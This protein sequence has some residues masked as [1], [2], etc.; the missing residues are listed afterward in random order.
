MRHSSGFRFAI[1]AAAG[2]AACAQAGC[3]LDVTF[4]DTDRNRDLIARFD[5]DEAAQ[6]AQD[7]GDAQD[8]PDAA[9]APPDAEPEV[10]PPIDGPS[11]ADALAWGGLL[12]RHVQG[13]CFDYGA[14]ARSP[15]ALD[16]LLLAQELLADADL[17]ALGDRDARRAFWVNAYNALTVAGVI[18]ARGLD[19]G[20]RV[21]DEGFAFFRQRR[22]VV[23]GLRLS[24]D[25]IEH[26]ILRGVA[27][28]PS[29]RAL[30]PVALDGALQESA[31]CAPFDPRLHFALN[32]A[33]RS[34]PDL[35]AEAYEGGRLDAQLA[36]QSATFLLNPSKGA[37][38]DGIS[39]LFVWFRPDFEAVAPVP[40]FIRAL[41]PGG[42]DGVAVERA[43]DYDWA[44]NDLDPAR[45]ECLAP[46]GE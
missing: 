7:A 43:L 10:R 31:R 29:A 45:P 9:Q 24:L 15:E 27:E 39:A 23:G 3:G 4:E 36:D 2:L 33:S 6:D 19:P 38:P 5:P 8:V 25:A 32:C 35:R 30:D 14:L 20:F 42:L 17:D 11:P 1:A 16:L 21:D 40:D 22:W 12:R 18:E 44:P 37:G 28:H 41:R 26:V 13:S 34:C 46:G